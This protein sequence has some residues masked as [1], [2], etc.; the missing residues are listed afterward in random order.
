MTYS[1]TEVY[2]VS[3]S[4]CRWQQSCRQ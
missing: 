3:D 4:G 1:F 2:S